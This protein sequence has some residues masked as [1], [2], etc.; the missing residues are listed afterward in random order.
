MLADAFVN[1]QVRP[2]Q[3]HEHRDARD[4]L[5]RI[6]RPRGRGHRRAEA[7]AAPIASTEPA[8]ARIARRR[9]PAATART[10]PVFMFRFIW[11]F[12]EA[13][14]RRDGRAAIAWSELQR[15]E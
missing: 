12:S 5:R 10:A 11:I 1:L 14:R 13:A 3:L 6:G 2:A 9:A 7:R 15:G 8:I 4:G